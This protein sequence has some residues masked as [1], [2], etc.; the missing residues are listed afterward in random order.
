[1]IQ[2]EAA[3]NEVAIIGGGPSGLFMLKKLIDEGS[4]LA[5][6]IFEKSQ[7]LGAGMPYSTQG[8][9]EEHVTNVSANEIPK[10]E[11]SITEWIVKVHPDTL[12]RF[13]IDLD[14]FHEYQVLPRL[15]FGQYLSDQFR[16]LQK[17]AIEAGIALQV[18]YGVEVVDILDIPN[19]EQVELKFADGQKIRFERV[20]LCTGHFWPK[21]HEGKIPGYFDSPYPPVKLKQ[22]FNHAVAIRGASLTAIDAL[23]TLARQHG[24]YERSADGVLQYMRNKENADFSIVMHSREGLLPGIRF[25]LD[26]PILGKDS[27]F[28]LDEIHK[29]RED[30]EGFVPLDLVFE[31][32]FKKPLAEVD[33]EFYN[34]IASLNIEEFIDRM[35]SL[36]ER[37]DPFQL[38][39]AEYKE[40]AK[41]IR[42]HKSVHWKEMLC[43]LSYT[44]NYPAKYFSAEDMIR[45]KRTLMPLISLII[46]FV[47]QSSAEELLALHDA[48]VLELIA[49]GNSS[50]VRPLEEG[51]IEYDIEDGN[52]VN[53]TTRYLTFIDCIGQPHLS[54]DAIPH[55][56]LKENH[57]VAPARLSFR[58]QELAVKMASENQDIELDHQGNYYL[59]VPGLAINDCFQVVDHYFALNPRIYVMAVPFIGGYNPDYSGLDFCETAATR[60][61]VAL[62]AANDNQN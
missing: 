8:A 45:L 23:R 54:F 9:N 18:T 30:N 48:S 14:R 62:R 16:L 52:G 2:N 34:K 42:Q 51:G 17:K 22:I 32:K 61:A 36:R 58:N 31:E 43:G 33:P 35:M 27:L 7:Q 19:V 55:A 60:I 37:L 44:L 3:V 59:R 26:E 56:G 12:A 49:V 41:S 40:A 50:E 46:A 20:I 39:R 6:H 15:L 24:H 38:F 21:Q 11:Q 13:S 5:V 29:I 47:P 53:K 4:K 10:L 28:D 1:M 25:H 57:T